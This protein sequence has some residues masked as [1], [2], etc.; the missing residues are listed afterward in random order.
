MFKK[1]NKNSKKMSLKKKIALVLGSIV[2]I[3]A[4]S[5]GGLL[6]YV[7]QMTHV[8]ANDVPKYVD[9]KGKEISLED[10]PTQDP[11][12]TEQEGITNILLIGTDGRDEKEA[13]R[14]DSIIIATIDANN[15]KIRFTAI[16]RDTYV[17]IPKY[18]PA[19]I[20]EAYQLGGPDLLL[21]T[22]ETNFRIK[23]DNY[24]I[25]NFWG[26]QDIIDAVGGVDIDVKDSEVKEIN[27]YIGE[28][29]KVKSPPL[30]HGG[31]QHLDGQQ[32]LAYSRIRYVGNGTY[33]RME[34]QEQVLTVLLNKFKTMTSLQ[35]TNLATKLLKCVKTNME[36]T[37]LLNDAYTVS[38]FGGINV[39]KLSIPLD[40]ISWGGMYKG[41]WYLLVDKDQNAKVLNDFVYKDITPDDSKLDVSAFKSVLRKYFNDAGEEMPKLDN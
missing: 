25:V 10:V 39:E 26:F 24:I 36:P 1:K 19:K 8:N 11:I 41:A 32:A 20:N 4:L 13:A 31:T 3:I 5:F 37:T 6:L 9:E 21:K 38:K 28:V 17:D 23:L 30:T 29:D 7:R 35:Y 18:K 14:S 2:A 40:K 22:I 12:Y 15:K 16:Q 27:K 33:E 34:R